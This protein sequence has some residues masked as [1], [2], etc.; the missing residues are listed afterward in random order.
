MVYVALIEATKFF[1]PVDA[2]EIGENRFLIVKNVQFDPEDNSSVFQFLPGDTVLC[3]LQT[4]EDF[5]GEKKQILVADS[6]VS[7]TYPDRDLYMLKF[8]IVEQDGRLT[9]DQLLYFKRDLEKL[10]NG[11]AKYTNTKEN[12]FHPA[13]LRW[14]DRASSG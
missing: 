2:K 11:I 1:I 14:F 13:I 12:P 8:L 10:M 6:L 5:K 3:K 9:A 7:S 4:R